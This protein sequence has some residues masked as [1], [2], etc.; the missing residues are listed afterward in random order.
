MSKQGDEDTQFI[1]LFPL[2]L[3]ICRKFSHNKKFLKIDYHIDCVEP[4]KGSECA[5]TKSEQRFMKIDAAI[6]R[7]TVGGKAQ[8]TIQRRR[9]P[10]PGQWPWK[11]ME[12]DF[13]KKQPCNLVVGSWQRGAQRGSRGGEGQGRQRGGRPGAG[14]E[15]RGEGT[16]S[17][18]QAPWAAG[19]GMA[20]QRRR[21]MRGGGELR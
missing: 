21:G 3:H 2:L 14:A 15:S 5:E 20:S 10:K 13:K 12:T 18:G 7:R 17:K 6:L 16:A 19:P 11:Q 4:G 8:E 1:T 9:E